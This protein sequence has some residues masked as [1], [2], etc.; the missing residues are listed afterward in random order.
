MSANK[1][2][3]YRPVLRVRGD[4]LLLEK[5]QVPPRLRSRLQCPMGTRDTGWRVRRR[6]LTRSLPVPPGLQPLVDAWRRLAAA[7]DSAGSLAD[8]LLVLR[9]S[10]CPPGPGVPVSVP[11][12][13]PVDLR[14][15]LGCG[16]A[17]RSVLRDWSRFRPAAE[18]I[19][20]R[21]GVDPDHWPQ[22]GG[23]GR[24]YFLTENSLAV[25]PRLV[26]ESLYPWMR[27]GG[28]AGEESAAFTRMIWDPAPDREALL[29]SCARVGGASWLPVVAAEPA[30]HHTALLRI[31][32]EL[33]AASFSAPSKVGGL[34]AAVRHLS[35][36]GDW[37]KHVQWALMH[38]SLGSEPVVAAACFRWHLRYGKELPVIAKG[39]V[40]PPLRVLHLVMRQ[41]ARQ[42]RGDPDV[43]WRWLSKDSAAVPVIR[44]ILGWNCR[45]PSWPQRLLFQ[46][47]ELV[48]DKSC[49]GWKRELFVAALPEMLSVARTMRRENLNPCAWLIENWIQDTPS[50]WPGHAEDLIYWLRRTAAAELPL[51]GCASWLLA[52][53]F[54]RLLPEGRAL[55]RTWSD[56]EMKRFAKKADGWGFGYSVND[57]LSPPIVPRVF[58]AQALHRHLRDMVEILH[59][60]SELKPEFRA[61]VWAALAAHPLC[62][63]D[64]ELMPLADAVVLLDAVGSG[65]SGVPDLPVSVRRLIASGD[66]SQAARLAEARERVRRRWWHLAVMLLRQLVDWEIRRG[67]PGLR[68]DDRPDLHTLCLVLENADT[69]ENR[70]PYRQL[71]RAIDEG[72][73]H[74]SWALGLPLNGAWLRAHAV[75]RHPAWKEGFSVSVR[76]PEAG[77][78][79]LSLEDDLQ[80]ILRMGTRFGTCLSFG[81]CN[82][83]SPAAVA[84]DANKRVLHA[85]DAAGKIIA[86]QLLALTDNGDLVCFPVYALRHRAAM[87]AAF[88]TY[89][90][91]LSQ[92]LKAPVWR[93]RE[94]YEIRAIVC[95]HWYD[96]GAWRFWRDH[97]EQTS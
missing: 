34:L 45:I 20:R 72:C 7:T 93:S 49:P 35:S 57:A 85:R 24:N 43:L 63:C 17:L 16:V 80:E 2:L 6:S 22:E 12:G 5:V 94:D 40:R 78:V 67:F 88:A 65:Q 51:P 75:A 26:A 73:G 11:C 48:R 76:L 79:T 84:L 52:G 71:L 44:R 70:G 47:F 19:L 42:F 32:L 15:A 91:T 41:D 69:E 39:A 1:K 96:D 37:L 4:L 60:I 54:Q 87:R 64:P 29:I 55:L 74:R 59:A 68:T 86:R 21:A 50:T 66:T 61:K 30:S 58:L 13:R 77:E 36:A 25:R 3:E 90:L 62:E 53:C 46:F 38:V 10:V 95:R 8:L 23:L 33:E 18:G 82:S 81:G 31:L 97:V 56:D 83:H 9:Y 14:P 27:P 92:A 89:D 28:P